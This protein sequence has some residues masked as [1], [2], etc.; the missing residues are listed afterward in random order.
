M[1]LGWV[2]LLDASGYRS[3]GD[4]LMSRLLPRV[5]L[6]LAILAL[7][8]VASPFHGAAQNAPNRPQQAAVQEAAVVVLITEQEAALAP[9]NKGSVAVANVDDL[10]N[11][12]ITRIPKI[13]LASPDV[14]ATASPIHFEIRFLAFNGARI[15]PKRVRIT[16]LK[17][18]PVDLTP[19]VTAFIRSDGIDVPRARVAPGRHQIQIDVVDTEGRQGSKILELDIAG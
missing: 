16:Y 3:C 19:R 8:I 5:W 9:P 1:V 2:G 12:A 15:E 14:P 4:S 11:R 7:A 6:A 13:I 18:S 10:D 17:Q